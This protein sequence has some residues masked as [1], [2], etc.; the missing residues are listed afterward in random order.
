MMKQTPILLFFLCVA[1]IG[2][3]AQNT[4]TTVNETVIYNQCSS[5]FKTPA[6]RD[7]I[8][9]IPLVD[10]QTAFINDTPKP[11]KMSR[12][13]D[14]KSVTDLGIPEHNNIDPALQKAPATRPDNTYRTVVNINGQNGGFPPDPTG[15]A[16]Q[17]Y[18]VQAVNSIVRIYQKNGFPQTGSFALDSFWERPGRGDPI[19]MYDRYAQRWFISQFFGDPEDEVTNGIL[20]AV[21]TTSDPLGEYYAYE[22]DYVDF[23]DYPKFSVWSNAYFMTANSLNTD[24]SAFEREKMLVGDPTAS[25]I[26]MDFPSIPLYF[27]SIAPSYAEGWRPPEDNAP[28]FFF[29]VQDNSFDGVET[30]HIKVI[31]SSINWDAPWTSTLTIH[32]E[33]P[34]QPFNTVFS[35]TWDDITQRGTD[36]KLDAV[37]GIFMYRAQYRRFEDYNV[38]MLCH[39][40]DVDNTNRAGIRWY[41][42][43]EANNGIWTIHQQSTYA[44]DSENSRWMGSVSMDALGHIAMAYSF[45]GPSHFPGLRYTGRFQEDPLNEMT[46]PEQIGVNGQAAQTAGRRYGD[47]AQMSVDPVDD[48]THWFTGEYIGTF[49]ARRTRIMAFSA[50][51]LASDEFNEQLPAQFNAYQ[52]H[53]GTISLTWQN[54]STDPTLTVRVTDITGKLIVATTM[55]NTGNAEI[56]VPSTA[57]GIYVVQLGSPEKRLIRKIYIGR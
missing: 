36:Q 52:P 10:D 38:T 23:P 53:A 43:R 45:T 33:I 37:T 28:C 29:A 2:A 57:K 39:T 47:Y 4:D 55:Q 40:V 31:K 24:F 3:N 26:K 9:V 19:V 12:Y 8:K 50:F 27:N 13:S 18:Y 48:Y 35:E 42:L 46:V 22:F 25:V 6:L 11:Y 30:D 7:L 5:F 16:G 56:D 1:Q 21:S 20:I 17:E 32:Q 14:I 44:P 34:T 41:E 49:G 51:H 54:V 15:A